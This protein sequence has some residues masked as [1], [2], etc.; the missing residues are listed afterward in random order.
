MQTIPNAL[1]TT[2]NGRNLSTAVLW[3]DN[4]FYT[5]RNDFAKQYKI[6]NGVLG[7]TPFEQATHQYGFSATSAMSS[8]GATS[9]ILWTVEGGANVLHAYDASNISSEFYNSTQAGSRDSLGSTVRFNVPVI[10]NGKVYI[11][12]AT[13]V[14]VYG[15]LP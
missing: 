10:A 2:A 13:E 6:A 5:G 15:L 8:N 12:T 9:G 14:V 1:G 11:G 3:Q 7:T 4:T